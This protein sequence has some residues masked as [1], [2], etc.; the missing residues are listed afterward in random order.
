MDVRWEDGRKVAVLRSGVVVA[1]DTDAPIDVRFTWDNDRMLRESRVAPGG[2]AVLP[3]VALHDARVSVRHAGTSS[4]CP[5]R[6]GP[7]LPPKCAAP[8]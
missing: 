2:Q 8:P 7:H 1:N 5:A 3:I 4:M 6:R